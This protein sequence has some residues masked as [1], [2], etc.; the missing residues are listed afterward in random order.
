MGDDEGASEWLDGDGWLSTLAPL[1][2]D[3]LLSDTR[4]LYLAWLANVE[5]VGVEEDELEPPVPAGLG[6]L[7]T[8][9][10]RLIQFLEIDKDLL[11]VAAI[12]SADLQSTPDHVLRNVIAHL[13]RNECDDI[14]WRLAQGELNLGAK[15]LRRLHEMIDTPAPADQPRRTVGALLAARDQL[16]KE[17]QQKQHKAAQA[18]RIQELEAL[19]QREAAVW[20]EVDQLIQ[21]YQPNTYKQAV[22]L[23]VELRDLA[24]HKG[25]QAAFQARIDHIH[26]QYA[27]RPSLIASLKS[28]GLAPA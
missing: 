24:R 13:S 10:Y 4:S 15:L 9:L 17:E 2:N 27:R 23:L 21:T 18:R 12:V 8:P 14:L 6:T 11:Q 19:A 7:T 28:A 16:V 20:Q 26:Q 25:A 3:L 1:R 5:R 22:A